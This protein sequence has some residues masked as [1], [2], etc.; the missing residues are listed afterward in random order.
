MRPDSHRLWGLRGPLITLATLSGGCSPATEPAPPVDSALRVEY[1]G[2]AA[3][4]DPGPVCVLGES[5]TVK[6]WV[7]P[8]PD[9]R[10][11]RGRLEFT[12]DGR[13]LASSGI[14]VAGGER[15]AIEIP[16][17]AAELA[18]RARG[19]TELVWTLP[20]AELP[21]WLSEVKRR[22]FA[23]DG[24]AARELLEEQVATGSPSDRALAL[25]TLGRIEHGRGEYRSAA[26]LLRL[27]IA[28]H[29]DAGRPLDEIHDTTL[30]A[31]R[32]IEVR[33]F[34]EARELLDRLEPAAEAAAEARFYVA[35][36]RG[37]LAAK[38]GDFRT[39][40]AE[41]RDA[42]AQAERVGLAQ[43]RW[44]AEQLLGWQLQTLGRS[45]EAAALFARLHQDPR[46]RSA[47]EWAELLTNQAWS[48]ILAREAGE[49]AADPTPELEEAL[50]AYGGEDCTRPGRRVNVLI[51]LA[52]AH[53]HHGRM[54]QARSALAQ[55]RELAA[56][57][58]ALHRLWWLDVEARIALED[59]RPG[60]ALD[61]YDELEELAASAF[62]PAGRWRAAAGRAR[63][64]EA[65]GDRPAA[66][67]ALSEAEVLLDGQSLR[68]PVHGG[69]GTFAAR[70]EPATRLYL[71]L[72]LEGGRD[73]E[74]LEV[75]RRSRSRL[76][77]SLRRGDRLARLEPA[78]QERWD[79]AIARY[80]EL[81]TDL[82]AAAA[83]DWRLPTD[84]LARV[85][86]GRQDRFRELEET[87]DQAFAVL[88][89]DGRDAALPALADG[90]LVLAYHP[91]SGGWVG[92][93]ATGQA[94]ATHRF[95]LPQAVLRNPVALAAR[96]LEPFREAIEDAPRLRVLPYG[97]LREV[98]FH[99]L[100]F[101]GDVLL[102]AGPVVYG[103]DLGTPPRP[104]RQE[105]RRAL[106]VA[107]PRNDLPAAGREAAA[108]RRVLESSGAA[109]EVE[110][111]GGPEAGAQA[112]RQAL[113][114]VDLLHYAGHGIFAGRGGLG[115]AMLL[116]DHS[117]LTAGDF[118]ALDRTPEMAVLSSC[119]TARSPAAAPAEG[120][121]LAQ[122]FLV[123]GSRQVVAA[124]RPVGDRAAGGL[125]A[126]FYDGWGADPDLAE[127]L[128]RAQ[129]AWRR[130]D[131]AAD[132]A[133]FRVLEP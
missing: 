84:Q 108:V 102:A 87:L 131:P 36:Y 125:F 67:E 10:T 54:P 13:Q 117:R 34:A 58:T 77:L 119:E 23:G 4:I 51:N 16:D 40:L 132:W 2:C 53:L 75:A 107:D 74:A 89:G 111:L 128:R 64:H 92:F 127:L 90:E 68:A 65:L 93:A 41:L 8:P 99:A 14:A 57:A 115:S 52:L 78:E 33:R 11:E 42:A 25:K 48:L 66:L 5:R 129:L 101:A 18:V 7:R 104:R 39:A 86:A 83:G 70:R 72:L 97:P 118:L 85:R 44:Q 35:Y 47:C 20:L 60:A 26:V 82:D 37:L 1:A 21:A 130:E 116:A 114:G 106:L 110:V 15:F 98:D 56:D 46:H 45:R 96:L 27:A 29:W 95:E 49:A 109:W 38:V 88:G 19:A 6:L 121:G 32:E 43:Q 61:L 100:P 126:R 124:V 3:V 79:R 22:W 103:L 59:A 28:A 76:L 17:P 31:D 133:S 55:A 123:A 113:G 122:A 30:L 9:A 69:R 12:A 112:V 71:E 81:R 73:A 94:V 80:L 91:L 105:P 62:S 63:A 120:I 24:E 50:E